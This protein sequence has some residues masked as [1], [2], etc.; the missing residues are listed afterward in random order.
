MT[1]QDEQ[2]ALLAGERPAPLPPAIAAQLEKNTS[3]EL[4]SAPVNVSN[5]V[6]SVAEA[7]GDMIAYIARAGI[8]GVGKHTPDVL[9]MFGVLRHRMEAAEEAL[10]GYAETKQRDLKPAKTDVSEHGPVP[11]AATGK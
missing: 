2:R 11:D 3:R 7:A 8:D 5:A 9:L 6:L 10:V 1:Q 4:A